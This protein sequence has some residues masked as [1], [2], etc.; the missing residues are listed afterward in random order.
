[1]RCLTLPNLTI[2]Y[3]Y[4][5]KPCQ[6]LPYYTL[7]NLAKL[8]H[9]IPCQTILYHTKPCQTKPYHSTHT[10][11]NHTIPYNV[12]TEQQQNETTPCQRPRLTFTNSLHPTETPQSHK[13][14]PQKHLV[15]Y[16]INA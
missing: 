1:M 9:T 7:P 3:M 2:P 15:L 14:W 12:F 16:I 5:N 11:P 10:M 8:Y 6:I 13:M 4:H